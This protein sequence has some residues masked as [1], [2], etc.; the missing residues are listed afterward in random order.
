MNKT[1]YER[2][3]GKEMQASGE[4]AISDAEQRVVNVVSILFLISVV[5]IFVTA[6]LP[7]SRIFLGVSIAFAAVMFLTVFAT[8]FLIV[9]RKNKEV[10]MDQHYYAG[11]SLDDSVQLRE[12]MAGMIEQMIEHGEPKLGEIVK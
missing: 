4:W 5:A 11:G 12:T 7:I 8:L 6:M 3:K 1:L 10:P 9:F 2:K